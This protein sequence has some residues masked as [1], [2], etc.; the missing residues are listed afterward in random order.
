MSAGFRAVRFGVLKEQSE[1]GGECSRWAW[2]SQ[3]K[4]V[5]L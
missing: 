2:K 1:A 4:W 3:V 5:R